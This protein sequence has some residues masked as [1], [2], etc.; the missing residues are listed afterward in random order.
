M[1]THIVIAYHFYVLESRQHESLQKLTANTAS[2]H[3]EH[4]CFLHLH[5]QTVP[6]ERLQGYE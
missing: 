2:S 1:V 6:L 4:L 3:T 5:G